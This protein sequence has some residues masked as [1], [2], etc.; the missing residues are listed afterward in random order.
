MFADGKDNKEEKRNGP[1]CSSISSM[2]KDFGLI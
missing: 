2:Q 1:S